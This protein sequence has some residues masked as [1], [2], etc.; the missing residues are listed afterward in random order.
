M[1]V[2]PEKGEIDEKQILCFSQKWKDETLKEGTDFR[3]SMSSVSGRVKGYN[4]NQEDGLYITNI[5][6]N[7]SISGLDIKAFENIME[8]AS[9]QRE[10]DL[11]MR[12]M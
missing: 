9:F 11:L 6:Y 7:G 8:K 12:D 2:K 4:Y 1:K 3:V 10:R 5:V